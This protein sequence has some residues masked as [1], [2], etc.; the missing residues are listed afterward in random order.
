MSDRTPSFFMLVPGPFTEAA[1]ITAAAQA[2]GL[3]S[4]VRGD[5]P[6]QPGDIV[7]D[8]IDAGELGPCALIELGMRLDDDP[9]RVARLGRALREAGGTQVRMEASGNFI[10]WETWLG[11]LESGE[12]RGLYF[13]GVILVAAEDGGLFSCGMHHF[14]LPDAEIKGLAVEDAA[15][16]L[17]LLNVWQLADK[18]V[19]GSGHTFQLSEETQTYAMERW[20]DHRHHP[21]DGRHN[22]FGLWRLMPKEACR[23]Q[24]QEPTPIPIPAL[25][26][27]LAA[28]E[29]RN[30]KPL[31][32]E[33]VGEVAA[34]CT[35]MAMAR[36]DAN[37]LERSRGYMDI[38]PELAWEQWQIV[39]TFF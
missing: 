1:T 8:A 36:K 14:G 32:A 6:L 3:S 21:S 28:V 24:V 20:P 10:D 35:C 5:Q 11:W 4:R 23:V 37:H 25:A 39:R 34:N 26:A 27:L 38:E 12:P 29:R 17:N 9:P 33:Q 16:W 15:N 30:G 13:A 19:L 22:P 31:T 7:V 2:T 18:P